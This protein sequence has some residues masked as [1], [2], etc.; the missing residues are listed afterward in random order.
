[1]TIE[2]ESAPGSQERFIAELRRINA[3]TE[4]FIIEARK[5]NAEAFKL[6]RDPW[7]SGLGAAAAIGAVVAGLIV[8]FSH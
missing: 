3:E 2:M 5:L 6:R 8:H 1:M 7:I 4:K